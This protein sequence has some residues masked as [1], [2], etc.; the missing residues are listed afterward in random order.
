[1]RISLDLEDGYASLTES[2]A[3]AASSVECLLHYKDDK[4]S[5][6]VKVDCKNDCKNGRYSGTIELKNENTGQ[7]Q[8]IFMKIFKSDVANF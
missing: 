5:T 4:E 6:P 7:F 2:S 1:M 8:V 3:M